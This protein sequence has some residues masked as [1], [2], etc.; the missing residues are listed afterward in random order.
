MKHPGP[1]P[2]ISV[3]IPTYN[4][5]HLLQK[6]LPDVVRILQDGDEII[7][8]DDASTD[9]TAQWVKSFHPEKS[10][11]IKL[12]KHTKN[13]RFAAAVNTGV[14]TAKHP[15]VFLLNNDV[16]PLSKDIREQILEPFLT[17][18][19]LFAVGCAEV[20]E[21]SPD[22]IISG[23]GTG[24][25][26]R[27]LLVHWY[28]P[29][30][31]STRTLWTAGGSMALDRAKFLEIGGMDTLFYPAYEEDRDLSYRALKHGWKI[32]FLPSARVLHQHE[33]TN[34]TVFG[35]RN[36]AV[37]SWKNQFLMVWK[38]ITDRWLLA[39]HL[40]WLPY[41]L[42]ITNWR[43]RGAVMAGFWK[44]LLQFS[45]LRRKREQAQKLWV[46][47]DRAILAEGR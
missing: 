14:E 11:K 36:M 6:H 40:L 18:P 33:T 19:E 42:T 46:R 37:M 5:R 1:N 3:V 21:D 16:S 9:D 32:K 30:Q 7:I 34:T 12:E 45:E 38:N 15:Y 39:Q 24:G 28:D 43:S 10:I 41:H 17:D 13:K 47:S 26:R 31:N 23:R 8:V 2:N 20:T 25:F 29:N 27:G 44:A 22:A 4:A 35:R